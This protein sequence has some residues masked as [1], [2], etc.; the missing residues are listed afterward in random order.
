VLL[1]VALLKNSKGEIDLNLPVSGSLDDPQF[2]VFGIILKIIGNLL[3]KAATAPFALI[4]AIVGGGGEDLAFVDF[5]AGVAG[6]VAPG[7]EDKL[8]K[9]A[10]ALNDRPS[11]RLD[12]AGRVDPATDME[13]LHKRALL[14]K[15]AAQRQDDSV[16]KGEASTSAETMAI[17]PAEYPALLKRAYDSEKFTK[18]RNAIG[19][20]RDL[21]PAEMEKLMLVNITVT[22]VELN[23][24]GER[25]ANA[26]KNAL[27]MLGVAAER[28]FIVAAV[29]K[30]DAKRAARVD[31]VL[32]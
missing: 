22:Q 20:A 25:R 5:Q 14:R 21:P 17:P 32:K 24:L 30:P 8:A 15:L 29:E 26:A 18:P 9:I 23:E 11:L 6:S 13:A 28:M 16:S 7:Q 12:I 19:V 4:G 2:S 31:F 27:G 10:K 1:A 3:V